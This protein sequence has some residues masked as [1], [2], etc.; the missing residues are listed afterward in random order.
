MQKFKYQ[1]KKDDRIC[2]TEI[3]NKI[4]RIVGEI[5]GLLKGQHFRGQMG[6]EKKAG[7]LIKKGVNSALTTYFFGQNMKRKLTIDKFLEFQQQLQREILS[8]EFERRNPDENGRIIEVDFTELLLAYAGYPDKKIA[9]IRK[10]VKKRFKD[11]PK[12]IYKD[13]YLK[14]FHFLNNINNVDIALTFYHIAG[15]SIEQG[16]YLKWQKQWLMLILVTINKEFVAV[17]KNRFLRGLEKSK[18]FVKLIESV[19]KCL[20]VNYNMHFDN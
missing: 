8:L 19:V 15:A 3:R 5:S 7:S 10:T 13:E 11:N 6:H 14:F 18:G 20:K 1:R 9:R 4:Y 2:C 17:M 12:G 16:V